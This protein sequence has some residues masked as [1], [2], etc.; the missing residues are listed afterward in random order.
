LRAKTGLVSLWLCRPSKR[1]EKYWLC[2][3]AKLRG[4][5]G[6]DSLL[7]GVRLYL[8][9]F[10]TANSLHSPTNYLHQKHPF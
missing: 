3:K 7:T 8:T 10:R 2:R 5:K 6:S 1:Q 4:E 9:H